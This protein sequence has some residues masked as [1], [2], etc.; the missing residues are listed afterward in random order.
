M[1]IN[2]QIAINI[3]YDSFKFTYKKLR[4]IIYSI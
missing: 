4:G 1:K 3:F 2:D